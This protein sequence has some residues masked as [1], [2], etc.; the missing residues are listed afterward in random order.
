M[1]QDYFTNLK[2]KTYTSYLCLRETTKPE[3]NFIKYV[4]NQD[5][6]NINNI[7]TNNINNNININQKNAENK[8]PMNI[9]HKQIIFEENKLMSFKVNYFCNGKN[10]E[11]N[12]YQNL[13]SNVNTDLEDNNIC[14]HPFDEKITELYSDSDEYI[15]CKCNQCF[16]NQKLLI[17]C[18]YYDEENDKYIIDF[19]LLSPMSLL[20]QKW[21]QNNSELDPSY[22]SEKYLE[23]Y[24]SAIFYFY[25]QNLPCEFL[26]P[27]INND[28]DNE[29]INELKEIRNMSY[30]NI[31]SEEF[32]EK[33]E[34]DKVIIV[35]NKKKE[36]IDE[37][38][39]IIFSGEGGDE[40]INGKK[41]IKENKKYNVTS[42]EKNL[43]SCFKGG[44]K[45]SKN[46]EF[47]LSFKP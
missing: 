38:N 1:N 4:I 32:Y 20:T 14:N 2:N 24:L 22:I 33:K 36:K 15:Q 25:E 41:E 46:V 45:G 40:E 8:S 23:C 37:N 12:L 9:Q 13:N 31:N 39:K 47:K 30:S 28:N 44:K 35:E 27:N 18:E 16:K 34:F 7:N 42:L 10:E 19:E 26:M 17:S 43:K 5:I 6:L 21:F 3:N 29:N 11:L